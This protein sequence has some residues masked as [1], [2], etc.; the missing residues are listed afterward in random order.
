MAFFNSSTTTTPF[1]RNVTLEV[2][3]TG[4]PS[5]PKKTYS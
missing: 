5:S 4:S 1:G 2:L 3:R